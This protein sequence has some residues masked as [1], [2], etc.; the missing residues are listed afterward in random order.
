[1]GATDVWLQQNSAGNQSL[2]GLVDSRNC[3]DLHLHYQGAGGRITQN[4]YNELTNYF[5]NQSQVENQFTTTQ[6][7]KV[8]ANS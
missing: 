1:M 6:Y 4:M 5:I 2:T 8:I 3:E 7:N